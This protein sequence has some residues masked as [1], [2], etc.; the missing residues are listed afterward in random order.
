MYVIGGSRILQ[1]AN[2]PN[3]LKKL[4]KNEKILILRRGCGELQG[5]P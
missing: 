5:R 2:L 4:H 1:D 3:R